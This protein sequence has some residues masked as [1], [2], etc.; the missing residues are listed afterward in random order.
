MLIAIA[1]ATDALW[2]TLRVHGALKI[3]GAALVMGVAVTGMHYTGMYGMSVEAHPAGPVTGAKAIDFLLPL[4]V[5]ISVITMGLLLAVMLSPSE[6]SCTGRRSSS[7]GWRDAS[8]RGHRPP[9]A[10]ARARR[11]W[12]SSARPALEL[13]LRYGLRRVVG[14]RLAAAQAVP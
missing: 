8:R 9:V 10:P 4:I 1:A 5:G 14:R 2:F 11:K 13:C 7:P 12:I 3:G 6:R